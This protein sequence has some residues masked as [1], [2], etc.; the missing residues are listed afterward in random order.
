MSGRSLAT[1]SANSE[2]TNRT[3]KIQNDHSPRRLRRK[4][5]SR[6][7]F[8]GPS[9]S[10]P[11]LR[12]GLPASIKISDLPR[13]KVDARIDPGVGQV[14]NEVHDEAKQRENIEIAKHNRIIAVH[15]RIEREITE[16][17][18]REYLFD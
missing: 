2:S 5:C 11:L 4:L 1:N 6:R 13:F 18:E 3:R 15:Q 7:R 17:V 10:Q 8:I 16:P 14:G 9:R 12:G